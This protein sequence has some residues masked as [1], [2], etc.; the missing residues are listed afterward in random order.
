MA[1]IFHGGSFVGLGGEF[2]TEVN[3]N[4]S[5]AN[6]TQSKEEKRPNH[7]LGSNTIEKIDWGPPSSDV[8]RYIEESVKAKSEPDRLQAA[9]SFVYDNEVK[10]EE[11][12]E[13]KEGK[14]ETAEDQ[15]SVTIEGESEEEDDEETVL[16]KSIFTCDHCQKTFTQKHALKSHLKIHLEKFTCGICG[17][18]LHRKDN[19]M[20]HL[21]KHENNNSCHVCGMEFPSPEDKTKHLKEDHGIMGSEVYTPEFKINAVKKIEE[22]GLRAVSKELNVLESTLTD[23]QKVIFNPLHCSECEKTYKDEAALKRHIKNIHNDDVLLHQ[24][25]QCPKSF[26]SSY[27]LNRHLNSCQGMVEKVKKEPELCPYCFKKFIRKDCLLDHIKCVHEKQKDY[28]CEYCTK[29]FGRKYELNNHIISVHEKGGKYACP[30]CAKR[31]PKESDMRIHERVHTG[32]KP[33]VCDSCGRAFASR[34]SLK[35]HSE[36][37]GEK[38]WL[39]STCG[40]GFTNARAKRIMLRCGK[41]QTP[42]TPVDLSFN[43]NQSIP[44]HEKVEEKEIVKK[45]FSETQK[46]NSL[47]TD[48][49]LQK[50]YFE[51]FSS[52]SDAGSQI[53]SKL[54]SEEDGAQKDAQEL[55][56]VEMNP[57]SEEEDEIKEEPMEDT[58]DD[59][60]EVWT[61]GW[62]GGG[63][64]EEEEEEEE[65]LNNLSEVQVEEAAF[66]ED[67]K[68]KRNVKKPKIKKNTEQK[69]NVK[70]P[71]VSSLCVQS[72]EE[73]HQ[74]NECGKIFSQKKHMNRHK[75]R[76]H[77][78]E[79]DQ[80]FCHICTKTFGRKE[81]MTRH[82]EDVHEK[83][84]GII[85]HCD[86]C[87]KTFKSKQQLKM[88]IKINHDMVRDFF[89]DICTKT[90]GFKRSLL[91]HIAD[92]HEKN[93]PYACEFCPRKFFSPV[94]L[95]R[96][97][98]KHTG[99]KPHQCDTCGTK[100]SYISTAR[101]H[102]KLCPGRESSKN[103]QRKE[104]KSEVVFDTKE[105]HNDLPVSEYESTHH[106]DQAVVYHQH[107]PYNLPFPGFPFNTWR[108]NSA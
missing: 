6:V 15:S 93:G 8:I 106:H 55:L 33:F 50:L 72:M 95:K 31:Y 49:D 98:T 69:S 10:K 43:K 57:E 54:F 77:S 82:I 73:I 81:H 2:S 47:K 88:H 51:R 107:P 100:F 86:K 91:R 42:L 67:K 74:C 87:E 65:V 52:S 68:K 24:C 60:G 12:T 61:G 27:K 26:S 103:R 66:K 59:W 23:W 85:L 38:P 53:M 39:C 63:K 13:D 84:P 7:H 19:Y 97:E 37:H 62:E 89:C 1:Q 18:V 101:K 35:L 99:E 80:F 108:G 11:Y 102:A 20:R 45:N 44:P 29:G 90:F 25:H 70:E 32:E 22:I 92:I 21:R 36:Q 104:K 94:D 4:S 83:K 9:L 58:E 17:T 28:V 76:V 79:K 46:T 16:E 75:R 48:L 14:K 64:G 71:P 56:K 40:E 41:C 96:H 34:K 5:A 105:Y 78:T 30:Y 3:H